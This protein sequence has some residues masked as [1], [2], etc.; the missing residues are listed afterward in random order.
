MSKVSPG[1][2]G[3]ASTVTQHLNTVE[4]DASHVN[5]LDI[6]GKGLSR[7]LLRFCISHFSRPFLCCVTARRNFLR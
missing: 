7:F 2:P 5:L 1:L 6:T 4:R 3:H